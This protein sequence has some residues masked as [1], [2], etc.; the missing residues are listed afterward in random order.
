VVIGLE[1]FD[2]GAINLSTSTVPALDGGGGDYF[3]VGSL[4]AWPQGTGVPFSLTD[5]SV[6]DLSGGGVFAGDVEG[7]FGMNRSSSDA[8]FGISDSD[9][10]GAAQTAS[11]TFNTTGATSLQFSVDFGGMAD[12]SSFGGYGTGKWV[13]FDIFAD[14]L[15]V[16]SVIFDALGDVVTTRLMDSGAA[17]GGSVLTAS[18]TLGLTKYD[19]STGLAVG[20][21][22]TDKATVAD[23]ALDT[24]LTGVFAASA[25]EVEI[26]LTADMPFEAA[27]FDNVA[28]V[29]VPTPGA[30]TLLGLG[31]LVATRR[32]RA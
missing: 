9:E 20:D 23:G 6:V 30:I 32:R 10:F 31:G 24:F 28:I 2:G 18:S 21:L 25:S 27:A 3:G 13:Q 11:W 29:G 7:V 19:A 1:D 22:Y 17:S 8:F 16:G 26:V 15:L 14:S 5:D 4:G 12:A